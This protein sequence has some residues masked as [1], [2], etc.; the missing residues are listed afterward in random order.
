MQHVK[1]FF[2]VNEIR[3]ILITRLDAKNEFLSDELSMLEVFTS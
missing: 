3:F 2:N 1:F